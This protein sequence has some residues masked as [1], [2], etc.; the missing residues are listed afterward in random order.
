[1]G[2]ILQKLIVLKIVF[3]AFYGIFYNFHLYRRTSWQWS[4]LQHISSKQKD[5]LHRLETPHTKTF[6]KL[7]SKRRGVVRVLIR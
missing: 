4:N 1:M 6:R 2:G 3:F 7:L 5:Y